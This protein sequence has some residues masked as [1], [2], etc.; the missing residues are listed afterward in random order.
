MFQRILC[1]ISGLIVAAEFTLPKGFAA[2][3]DKPGEDRVQWQAVA[4]YFSD[5]NPFP[6]GTPKRLR[7]FAGGRDSGAFQLAYDARGKLLRSLHDEGYLF[8]WDTTTGNETRWTRISPYPVRNRPSVLLNGRYVATAT[9]GYEVDL[10]DL[11]TETAKVRLDKQ[12]YY[13]G[14]TTLRLSGDGSRIAGLTLAE[15]IPGKTPVII[16]D[17]RTG[18]SLHEVDVPPYVHSL[19]LSLNG[20]TLITGR[21][22]PLKH[23]SIIQWWDVKTGNESRACKA[24]RAANDPRLL[25]K[26]TLVNDVFIVD[27]GKSLAIVEDHVYAEPP[28]RRRRSRSW[29]LPKVQLMSFFGEEKV[30]RIITCGDRSEYG[31]SMPIAFAPDGRSLVCVVEKTL[32]LQDITTGNVYET[33]TEPNYVAAVAFRPDGKQLATGD[34]SGTILLWDVSKLRE[35]QVAS[36]PPDIVTEEE[37]D[38]VVRQADTVNPA[39]K[40]DRRDGFLIYLFIGVASLVLICWLVRRW[41]ASRRRISVS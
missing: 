11:E 41:I 16:W 36:R 23:E 20:E 2:P 12:S 3:P 4:P 10:W 35:K 26:G 15:G 5:V 30:K 14:S 33:S 24:T 17:A 1:V 7:G 37:E 21:S 38:D 22:D 39:P 29:H 40:S 31:D 19:M 32:R 13:A 28:E 6:D 25:T 27:G 9:N 18:K 34:M 8:E